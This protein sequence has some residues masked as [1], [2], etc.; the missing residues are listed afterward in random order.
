M[1]DENYTCAIC[2][3]D[4][5]Y[6]FPDEFNPTCQDHRKYAKQ[7]N[8]EVIQ[9]QLGII[10][11]LPDRFNKCEYCQ[12]ELSEKEKNTIEADHV[13]ILCA[14]HRI[15]NVHKWF[16]SQMALKWIEY[17][18]QYPQANERNQEDFKHFRETMY[19]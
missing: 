17:K 9:L 14:K 6:P 7:F 2:G 18:Q 4:C 10:S 12:N 11:E 15:F 3:I 1:Q 8:A 16:Q 19:K 13:T 5:T